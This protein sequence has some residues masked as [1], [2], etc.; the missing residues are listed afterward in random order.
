MAKKNTDEIKC[1]VKNVI[2]LL[3][4][5]NK[6]WSKAVMSIAWFDNAPTVDIRNV[7]ISED[8]PRV[9]KGISLTNEE[10]DKLVS[11]LLDSGYG[12]LEDL[13]NAVKKKRSIFS[14][15]EEEVNKMYSDDD[16]GPM[17]IDIN[18]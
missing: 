3:K 4:E 9:G 1:E 10:A 14:I 2:G 12:S 18:I 17:K 5:P 16:G 7:N 8:P 6:D 13:E 11:V 15:L